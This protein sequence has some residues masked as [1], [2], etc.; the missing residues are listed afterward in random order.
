[1]NSELTPFEE[2]VLEQPAALQRLAAALLPND[3]ARIAS[4]DWDRV[5]FTGM[6]SSHFAGM[7]TW[8]SVCATGRSAWSIDTGQLLDSPELITPKTLLIATSQSGASGEIVELLN[9][10]QGRS[11][12]P[13]VLV[14]ITN[15]E[16]S[17]LAQAA[18]LNLPLH[19]GPE[20]TV[21]TKS[22]LNTLGVHRYIAGVFTGENPAAVVEEILQTAATVAHAIESSDLNEVATAALAYDHYRVAMVA[23]RDDSATALY[24][25]LITKEASK[26]AAEGFVGGQ[27]RHGPFELAGEG[28][29]VLLFGLRADRPDESLRRLAADLIATGSSVLVVGDDE[30]PGARTVQAPGRFSLEGLA[31][32]AVIAELFAISLARANGVTPGSFAYGSK[33]TRAL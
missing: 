14:G 29:T 30:I 7:P 10:I 12:A 1:M 28:L 3:F 20:A 33:I 15:D 26:V 2:D 11:I 4:Q 17:P 22:Y 27:F 21:S 24:A 13:G 23:R 31:T 16:S 9:R 32:G 18:D 25:A 8:R 19:S 6:G 5:V